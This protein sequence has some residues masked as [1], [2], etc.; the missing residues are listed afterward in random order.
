MDVYFASASPWL[1]MAKRI[2]DKHIGLCEYGEK[3]D[4]LVDL[5]KKMLYES[6]ERVGYKL[7][8]G[9]RA[10]EYSMTSFEK[11]ERD[12]FEALKTIAKKEA[13]AFADK[14]V[15]KYQGCSS[16][17]YQAMAKSKKEPEAL[18]QISQIEH[19][20]ERL[21]LEVQEALGVSSYRFPD[22]EFLSCEELGVLVESWE[23]A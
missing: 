18:E 19:E 11:L 16:F 9:T 8:I 4:S 2:Y 17:D 7:W 20:V 12:I 3:G 14:F 5:M 10:A 6:Y 22:P 15:K 13:C 21:R 23:S 1:W